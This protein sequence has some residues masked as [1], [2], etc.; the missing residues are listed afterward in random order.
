MPKRLLEQILE[1]SFIFCETVAIGKCQH[2]N[3]LIAL[4]GDRSRESVTYLLTL[5][6]EALP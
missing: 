3:L 2:R 5:I 6:G 4:R 1:Y